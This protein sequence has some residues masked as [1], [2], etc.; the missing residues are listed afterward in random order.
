[1]YLPQLAFAALG[2][3]W[4]TNFLFMKWASA[5]LS[6]AQI[7]FLRVLCGFL[8]LLLSALAKGALRWRDLRHAHHFVVMS[9]LATVIYYYAFAKGTGLLASGAAGMLSG[10]IPLVSAVCAWLLLRDERPT[11]RMG[12][13]LVCGFAGVLLIAQPWRV[14][15]DGVSLAG[16]GSM[17][18]GC[19]SVGCSFVYARRYL[20]GTG[21][22]PLALSTWQIGI[23][24]AIVAALTDFR[25]MGRIAEDP[26]ALAGIVLGLGVCGTGIAY[27]LYYYIVGR[28]GALT[29]AGVTYIPPVVALS[30]GTWIAGETLRPFDIVAAACILGGVYLLQ[31]QI[32]VKRRQLAEANRR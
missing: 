22:S 28:L 29:A 1:M 24:L 16:V 14:S 32:P 27:L 6:P 18:L 21:M 7:V 9:L 23:A 15:G 30:M 5:S 25:G 2:L 13:G 26:R 4:G 31:A 3:I 19:L 11:P 12:M 20:S 17:L 8:P 10:A